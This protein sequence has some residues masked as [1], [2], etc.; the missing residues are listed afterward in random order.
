M[1]ASEEWMTIQLLGNIDVDDLDR[2]IAFYGDAFGFRVGRRFGAFGVE[3][4]GGSSAIYL[5]A[6]PEGS[7]PSETTTERRRYRRHWTPVHLDVVVPDLDAALTRAE[8]AGARVEGEVRSHVW[9]RIAQLSDPFGHGVC[10][11]QFLG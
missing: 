3:M 10:L 4:L 7:A 1:P 9:G 2:A 11:V 8:A 5:L 6:K